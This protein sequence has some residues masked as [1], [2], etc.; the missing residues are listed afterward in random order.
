MDKDGCG[1]S[2]VWNILSD[3]PHDYLVLSYYYWD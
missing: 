1:S 2:R 3:I